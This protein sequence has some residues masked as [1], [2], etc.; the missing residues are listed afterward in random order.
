MPSPPCSPNPIRLEIELD[1]YGEH[2]EGRI[3]DGDGR[4][5]PFSGWLELMATLQ[6]LCES[7]VDPS[8]GPP[9]LQSAPDQVTE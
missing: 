4:Q 3:R 2:I 7:T 5:L 1:S 9:R 8:T 6:T